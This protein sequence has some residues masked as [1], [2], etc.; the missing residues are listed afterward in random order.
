MEI[1]VSAITY[2]VFIGLI[3]CPFFLKNRIEKLQTKN[4]FLIYLVTIIFASFLMT[5]VFAW[6]VNYSD[7]LLL[8]Y[9][10]YNFDG[11][12]EKEF[13][14]NVAAKDLKR[15]KEL[16]AS[17]SGIGWPAKVMLL[18]PFSFLYMLTAYFAVIFFKRK[19]EVTN[20]F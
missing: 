8:N 2:L 20:N 15:V 11:M 5:T 19:T 14:R 3:V 4:N 16:E 9:Y 7:T 1:T 6:W 13:Y 17:I 12:N 18:S 10:G